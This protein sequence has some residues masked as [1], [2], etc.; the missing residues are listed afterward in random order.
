[1]K[2]KK[3]QT[4]QLEKE[5]IR[6]LFQTPDYGTDL[7]VPYLAGKIWECASGSGYMQ[8][9]LSHHG[10]EVMATDIQDGFNFVTDEPNFGFD[11]IVTNPPF[12][13]KRKFY[14]R[15]LIYKKPFALL[16]P[17]DFCGWIVRA[18]YEDGAQWICPTRRIDY[19]TPTGKQGNES[20]APFHSGWFCV[21]MKLPKE[22]VTVELSLAT[23]ERA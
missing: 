5:Q 16:I 6:D 19:I 14:Q 1:M 22:I 4:E 3:P 10:F 23:K 15:C 11:M 13:L 18:M 9:R 21:G 17:M 12:S 8:R 7:V 2:P 20:S